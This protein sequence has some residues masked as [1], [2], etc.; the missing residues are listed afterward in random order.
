MRDDE[1]EDHDDDRA[2][3]LVVWRTKHALHGVMLKATS[4]NGG[5]AWYCCP[6]GA[7]LAIK[8]S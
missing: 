1:H 8:V 7:R 4:G 5:V 6:C 2:V 3:P